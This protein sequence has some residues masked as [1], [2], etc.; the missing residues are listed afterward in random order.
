MV[1]QKKLNKIIFIFLFHSFV[2]CCVHKKNITFY[3]ISSGGVSGNQSKKFKIKYKFFTKKYR[4]IDK[5]DLNGVLDLL[6]SNYGN[7]ITGQEFI[8]DDGFI[9]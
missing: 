3:T 1:D 2:S 5:E 4:M 8:V 6:I 7:K 9:L